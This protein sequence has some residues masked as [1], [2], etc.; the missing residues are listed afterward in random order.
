MTLV[1]LSPRKYVKKM[2]GRGMG[3]YSKVLTR[4]GYGIVDSIGQAATKHVLG[5][6]GHSTGKYYGKQLGKLI[7]DKTGSPLFGTIAKSALGSLG[8]LAGNK[9][10]ST[11]G[12][13]ISNNVFPEEEKKKSDKQK[14]VTLNQ[15]LEQARGKI[16]GQAGSGIKIYH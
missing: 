3:K 4:N 12:N 15:L 6:L 10:G 16:M 2:Y 5:G 14:K 8:G 7:G 11:I 13:V 9:L 1:K